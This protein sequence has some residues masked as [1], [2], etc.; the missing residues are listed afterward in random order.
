MDIIS[1]LLTFLESLANDPVAYL[2]IFYIFCILAAIILPIPV[3]FGLFLNPEVNILIKALVLGLGK[4]TGAFLIF[5]LGIKVE[6]PIRR[7]SRKWEWF[8]KFVDLM[9]RF[10]CKTRYIG[11]YILL[12]HPLD[13]RYRANL[14]ILG[15]QQGREGFGA[16]MVHSYEFPCGR[17]SGSDCLRHLLGLRDK[18]ALS[19][20]KSWIVGAGKRWR[21]RAK[22]YNRNANSTIWFGKRAYSR[23]LRSTKGTR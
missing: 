3:E 20:T 18:I 14:S 17:H 22:V 9:D 23:S 11:L 8:G 6:G 4:A 7:W 12:K 5:Y 21:F 19:Q 10:V 1:Q 16:E 2:V 15:I 13:D